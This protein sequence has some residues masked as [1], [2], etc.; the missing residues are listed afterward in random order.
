[1][2]IRNKWRCVGIE[3]DFWKTGLKNI[4]TG[5]RWAG[6]TAASPLWNP[7]HSHALRHRARH[8]VIQGPIPAGTLLACTYDT[9]PCHQTGAVQPQVGRTI[10][11]GSAEG[12][13]RRTPLSPRSSSTAHT[14]PFPC[15][16]AP[17]ARRD[18][19]ARCQIQATSALCARPAQGH[20]LCQ[21]PGG[22]MFSAWGTEW[23]QAEHFGRRSLLLPAGCYYNSSPVA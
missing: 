2:Q 15:T 22:T 7:A 11:N 1:M 8:I 5:S 19:A 4:H 13:G 3:K 10:L 9:G 17:R 6:G 14:A 23:P 20:V 18:T 12:G 21:L 16:P